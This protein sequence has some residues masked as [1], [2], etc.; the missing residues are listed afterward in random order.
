MKNIPLLLILSLI[1][2]SSCEKSINPITDLNF[3]KNSTQLLFFT[4]ENNIQNESTYYDA[5]LEIKK[6]YPKAIA[7]MKVFS[8]TDK[9]D[10]GKYEVASYPT[11]M[12]IYK[13]KIITEI[14]GNVPKQ[15]I[16]EQIKNTLNEKKEVDN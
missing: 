1:C 16:I 8:S 6:D 5:L 14:K 10:L 15:E 7:N 2:L 13:N 3:N 4:D 11:I 12:V 9:G